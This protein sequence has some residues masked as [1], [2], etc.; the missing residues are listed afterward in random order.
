MRRLFPLLKG[1][2]QP[3]GWMERAGMALLGM[4][5]HGYGLLQ[6][7]RVRAYQKGIVLQPWQADCPVVAV[8][9]LTAGGTG[10]TP[11]VAWLGRFFLSRNVRLAIVSRGYK[12]RSRSPITLVADPNG[13]ILRAPEAA[14]EAV[15]LA[16]ELPGATILTGAN[17]RLLIRHATQH[18]GCRLILMDDAFQHVPVRRDLDVLLLDA[19]NPLGNGRILPG[20]LLREFPAAMARAHAIIMTRAAQ[21][22]D[23]L[24]TSAV[25]HQFAPGM[26]TAYCYHK[27]LHWIRVGDGQILPLDALKGQQVLAFCGIAQPE[28]FRDTLHDIQVSPVHFIAYP[29]HHVVTVPEI[30]QL[31]ALAHAC[32]ASALVTTQKDWVKIPLNATHLPLYVLVIGISFPEPFSWLLQH[33]EIIASKACS[34]S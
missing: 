1:E 32:G 26:P 2:R 20:G 19:H 7:G 14:D 4:V 16:H 30:R 27:P 5:G 9:N 18:L 6:A 15:L 22:V 23:R 25:I 3:H 31:E 13:R 8:G 28:S 34:R 11:M 29:D 33:L 21:E 17:R 10:K 12:Q 24:A